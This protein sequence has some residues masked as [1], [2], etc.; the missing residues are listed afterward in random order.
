MNYYGYEAF[1]VFRL[2][3]LLRSYIPLHQLSEL[4]YE[5]AYDCSLV[6]VYNG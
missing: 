1:T 2:K 4:A 5:A 3:L 6:T